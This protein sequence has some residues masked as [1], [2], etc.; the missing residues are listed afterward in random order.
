MWL[1][2]Q[3]RDILFL[4]S[5]VSRGQ[6]FACFL[7]CLLKIEYEKDVEIYQLTFLQSCN[8]VDIHL[9]ITFIGLFLGVD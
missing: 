7:V 2:Y 9:K 1:T 4:L 5:Y 8:H 6:L 3:K